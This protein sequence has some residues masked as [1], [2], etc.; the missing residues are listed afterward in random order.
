MARLIESY[1]GETA[2]PKVSDGSNSTCC[3]SANFIDIKKKKKLIHLF[4]LKTS[5]FPFFF[6]FYRNKGFTKFFRTGIKACEEMCDENSN[7]LEIV[8]KISSLHSYD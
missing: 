1:Y 4:C 8:F 7:L 3:F 5:I 6:F 2:K